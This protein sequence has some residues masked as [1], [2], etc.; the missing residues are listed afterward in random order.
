MGFAP[1]CGKKK[2]T[3][4]V[5]GEKINSARSLPQGNRILEHFAIEVI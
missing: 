4:P 5:N 1:Q 3:L 2:S